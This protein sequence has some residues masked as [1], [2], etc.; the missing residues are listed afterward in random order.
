M[1][2]YEEYLELAS[3]GQGGVLSTDGLVPTIIDQIDNISIKFCYYE[4]KS[5]IGFIVP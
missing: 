3:G 5:N 4:S 1:F 2:F